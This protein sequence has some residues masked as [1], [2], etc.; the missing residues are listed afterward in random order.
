MWNEYYAPSTL[1][2]A[3]DL[4]SRHAGDGAG[5]RVIAGGTDLIIEL[6][7][8][9]R[10][11]GALI[12]ISRLPG[13][14]GIAL[15]EQGWIHLGPLVTHNQVIASR[16][17]VARAFPLARACREVGS[18]QIRN[19]ATVAGNLITA[20]PANDTITPLI[21][22]G[23]RV[24]LQSVR[25]SRTV[26][27]NEF[28][29]GV[30]KTVMAPDEI[31]TDIAF[32]ALDLATQRGTFLK[33]GLRQAQAISVV[34]CAVVRTTDDKG[35]T[36]DVA[37]TLGAVAPMIVRAL[38]AEAALIGR[39]L[40]EAV[41]A[42]ASDLAQRAAMPIDDVRASARYRRRMV[43]AFVRRALTQLMNGTER[44]GWSD[45]PALLWTNARNGDETGQTVEGSSLA[46]PAT[47]AVSPDPIRLTVNGRAY[48]V[49]GAQD[50]TLLRLLREDCGLIGTKE[51]CDE[52]EC[53]ACTVILDGKAVMS[54]LVPAPR[55]NGAR[56]VTVEGVNELERVNEWGAAQEGRE[57]EGRLH[58][59]QQAFID[60]G[61]VQ[62]GYCTPGFIV[63]G[64]AL[65]AEHPQP[66]M[67][68]IKE[69][70]S[71]NLCRCT[72]YYK[73]LS[74]F[75]RAAARQSAAESTRANE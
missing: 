55:A 13:L 56:I 44:D 2:E 15:D 5:A 65:L 67:S 1:N 29:R 7:R 69:S 26:A 14:D 42:Q 6:D 11:V 47:M 27:L 75:D 3:L 34:N 25:G 62:C 16:L 52:G 4:L 73:I 74:A 24:T 57:R 22:M 33:L 58:P 45:E 63:A 39:P 43:S 59:L 19:R 38:E 8:G 68:Q 60:E 32:H 51:G 9:T 28:Y 41:I 50:K 35:R 36:T 53:G 61:A 46:E 20:S 17:C 71:G 48:C 30:R 66:T 37:I 31:M 18:P 40:T 49:E 21:A 54:C 12:D 23:A 64:A 10:Q 70:L 72:G